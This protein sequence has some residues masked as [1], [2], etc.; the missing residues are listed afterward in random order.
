MVR[1][2]AE[3]EAFRRSVADSS[4]QPGG[5]VGKGKE[6][7]ERRFCPICDLTEIWVAV[8]ALSLVASERIQASLV[9]VTATEAQPAAAKLL[10]PLLVTLEKAA[11]VSP[12]PLASATSSTAASSA[13]RPPRDRTG[14]AVVIM[15]CGPRR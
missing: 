9:A 12:T 6:T 4:V 15:S 3:V 14:A 2:V 1:P 11:P 13:A 7:R 8:P 5:V 10:P